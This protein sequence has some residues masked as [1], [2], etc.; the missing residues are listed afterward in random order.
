MENPDGFVTSRKG[1]PDPITEADWDRMRASVAG[2]AEAS[3]RLAQRASEAA[4]SMVALG[5]R[6]HQAKARHERE[7]YRRGA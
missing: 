4:Q 2:V 7:S 6:L 3:G 1:C 5:E